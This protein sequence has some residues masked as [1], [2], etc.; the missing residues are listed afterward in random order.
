VGH[1]YKK[2]FTDTDEYILSNDVQLDFRYALNDRISFN[3]RWNYDLEERGLERWR[4]GG[5]YK[6]DCWSVYAS[7]GADVRPRPTT[8]TGEIEYDQ[9]YS[10]FLQLNFI[11]FGSI[12]TSMFDAMFNQDEAF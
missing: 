6:R 2:D 8:S 1:S 7:V 11:P 3:G 4:F 9:E 5:D 12:N 10:F